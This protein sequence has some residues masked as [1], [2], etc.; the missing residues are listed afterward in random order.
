M[1]LCC[2]LC[3]WD[4]PGTVDGWYPGIGGV[5]WEHAMYLGLERVEFKPLTD[6][7]RARLTAKE[8]KL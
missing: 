8:R 4:G 1:K 5:C 7:E 3:G 2:C 6:I